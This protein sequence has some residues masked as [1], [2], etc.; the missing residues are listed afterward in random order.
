MLGLILKT[1]E[2]TCFDVRNPS[3]FIKRSRFNVFNIEVS[4]CVRELYSGADCF[5]GSAV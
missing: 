2:R 3:C 1:E 4:L 5:G